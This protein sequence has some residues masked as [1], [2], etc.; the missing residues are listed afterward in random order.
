MKRNKFPGCKD[1]IFCNEELMRCK[2]ARDAI[3]SKAI[4]TQDLYTSPSWC[5]FRSP[6]VR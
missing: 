2:V 4:T 6:A 5:P 3:W 1:C